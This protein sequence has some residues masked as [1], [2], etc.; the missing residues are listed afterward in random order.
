MMLCP[1]F[2]RPKWRPCSPRSLRNIILGLN[3][4]HP[5]AIMK[6]LKQPS[7]PKNSQSGWCPIKMFLWQ[8]IIP[9]R[10]VL[11][12]LTLKIIKHKCMNINTITVVTFQNL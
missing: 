3:R 10:I 8:Q 1:C 2:R 4:G 6:K 7:F 11:T 9:T 12:L 5:L